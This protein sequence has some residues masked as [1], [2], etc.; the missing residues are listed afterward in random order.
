DTLVVDYGS[1]IVDY[2]NAKIPTLEEY[3]AICKKYNAVAMME[4]KVV[5]M[6]TEKYD[7]L[8]SVLKKCGFIGNS[9]LCSFN[10]NDLV[11]IRALDKAIALGYLSNY[12][13]TTEIDA[14]EKLG[15]A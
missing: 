6:T 8:L 7:S 9:I 4:I 14:C 12:A 2:P 13:T 11:E 15:N 3:L 5:N 10:Y 1:N